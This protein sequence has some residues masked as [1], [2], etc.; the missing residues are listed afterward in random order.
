[1]GEW[2]SQGYS[3]ALLPCENNAAAVFVVQKHRT[4]SSRGCRLLLCSGASRDVLR[5][6]EDPASTLLSVLTRALRTST[7]VTADIGNKSVDIP[8]IF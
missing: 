1:M 8:G 5:S 4:D 3:Q 7:P 6:D 2:E